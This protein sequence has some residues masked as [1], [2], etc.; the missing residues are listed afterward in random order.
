ML[1]S[2]HILAEVEALC[3]RVTIIRAGRAVETGTLAELRHLLADVGLAR[4]PTG[5]PTGLAALPGVH[6][7]QRRRH[8]ACRST[9]T[10]TTSDA[11]MRVAHRPSACAR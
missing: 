10:P 3:D 5:P 11:A 6:D 8:P 4:R 2:S 1:L 7:L 9:S